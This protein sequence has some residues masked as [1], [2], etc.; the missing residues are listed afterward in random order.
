[1]TLP[2]MR[3]AKK[4]VADYQHPRRLAEQYRLHHGPI[5][6]PIREAAPHAVGRHASRVYRPGKPR[7]AVAE[8]KHDRR[9]VDTR[10]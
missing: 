2:M 8:A 5:M 10:R 9:H 6:P 4:R 3:L 7:A 1:M